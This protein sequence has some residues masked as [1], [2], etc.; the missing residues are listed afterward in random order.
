[1]KLS[2]EKFRVFHSATGKHHE[3]VVQVCGGVD[4]HR[5]CLFSLID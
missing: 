2:Q 1:M 5:F 4:K 3:T